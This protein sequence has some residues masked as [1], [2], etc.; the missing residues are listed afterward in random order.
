M[1]KMVL[2]H[3]L[4]AHSVTFKM[5]RPLRVSTTNQLYSFLFSGHVIQ[6]PSIESFINVKKKNDTIL[7][8]LETKQKKLQ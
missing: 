2:L 1:V 5:K 7:C 6:F 4:I 8:I 3:V